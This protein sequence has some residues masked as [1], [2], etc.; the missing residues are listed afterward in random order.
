[1]NQDTNTLH[2]PKSP[3]P[4]TYDEKKAAEAAFQHLPCNP[5]WSEAAR[6]VYFGIVDAIA[7]LN[8]APSFTDTVWEHAA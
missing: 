5:E 1:M 7:R 3:R 6:G 2:I 4:L 8:P